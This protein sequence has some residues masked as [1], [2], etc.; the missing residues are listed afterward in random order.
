M[1]RALRDPAAI[2]AALAA[3]QFYASNGVTLARVD[4][5]NDELVIEVDPASPGDHVISFIVNGTQSQAVN[6]RSARAVIPATGYIR[7]VVTRAQDGAR[8]WVQPVRR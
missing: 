5:V 3:G 2:K 6:A 7:A 1:V 4:A 8:A